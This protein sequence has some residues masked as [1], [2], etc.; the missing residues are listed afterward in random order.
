[1]KTVLSDIDAALALMVCQRQIG[2]LQMPLF[3]LG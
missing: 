3:G 1:M 2:L